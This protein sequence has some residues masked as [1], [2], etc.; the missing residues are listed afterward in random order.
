ML[1]LTDVKLTNC[2]IAFRWTGVYAGGILQMTRMILNIRQTPDKLNFLRFQAAVVQ[3]EVSGLKDRSTL[4]KIYLRSRREY[5]VF[6]VDKA[7]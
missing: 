6:S 7:G 5:Q 1:S 4:Y 2:A 3:Q